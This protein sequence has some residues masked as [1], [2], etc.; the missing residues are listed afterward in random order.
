MILLICS[1]GYREEHDWFSVRPSLETLSISELGFDW[2]SV[3]TVCGGGA[4]EI[5]PPTHRDLF[6]K[7][8]VIF[9]SNLGNMYLNNTSNGFIFFSASFWYNKIPISLF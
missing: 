2:I 6:A 4:A 9:R 7:F 5:K 3:T 8:R 1:G